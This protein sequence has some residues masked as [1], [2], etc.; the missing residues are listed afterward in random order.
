MNEKDSIQLGEGNE[1][2]LCL[3]KPPAEQEMIH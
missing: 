2:H 3:R 1:G